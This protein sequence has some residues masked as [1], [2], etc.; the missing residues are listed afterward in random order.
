M[1]LEVLECIFDCFEGIFTA[2]DVKLFEFS[3]IDGAASI[4]VTFFELLIGFIAISLVLGFFLRSHVGSGLAG[5]GN[6][7]S[8]SYNDEHKRG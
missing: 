8:Y 5:I 7:V 4:E 3:A 2:L 1:F 6:L